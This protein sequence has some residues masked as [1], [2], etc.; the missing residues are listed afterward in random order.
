MGSSLLLG[1]AVA[2][3]TSDNRI[4]DG[5]KMECNTDSTITVFIPYDKPAELLTVSYGKCNNVSDITI[6]KEGANNYDFKITMDIVRCEM[7]NKLRTLDYNQTAEFTV[8]RYLGD[9]AIHFSDFAVKSYCSFESEYKVVFEYGNITESGQTF[10][11]SG[12]KVN[13]T[14]DMQAYS[15][16]YSGVLSQAPTQAGDMIYLGLKVN[17]TNFDKLFTPT[18]CEVV[19]SNNM[20]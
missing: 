9:T 8:G 6:E 14:F 17:N 12:G 7:D 4:K 16:D 13:L 2:T 5:F 18:K 1:A 11:G 19:S 20:K 15:S 10:T 3:D